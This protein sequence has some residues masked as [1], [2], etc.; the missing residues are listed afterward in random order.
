M[1]GL[2]K[3]LHSSS[4]D[5]QIRAERVWHQE[6]P[7]GW[8]PGLSGVGNAQQLAQVLDEPLLERAHG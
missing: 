3:L 4:A 2:R 8:P 6:F 1:A 7:L 5:R